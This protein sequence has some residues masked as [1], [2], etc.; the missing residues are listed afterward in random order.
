MAGLEEFGCGG[1]VKI[2]IDK[3]QAF[4]HYAQAVLAQPGGCLAAVV[5]W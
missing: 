2:R 3:G 4:F 5:G 1:G